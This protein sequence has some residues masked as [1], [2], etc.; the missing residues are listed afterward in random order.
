MINNLDD[1]TTL[2]CILV[3]ICLVAIYVI[4]GEW[5]FLAKL[6]QDYAFMRRVFEHMVPESILINE[7]VI[8]QKFII[9]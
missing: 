4:L 3:S 2:L 6:T 8:K 5:V 7:K 1:T 9:N